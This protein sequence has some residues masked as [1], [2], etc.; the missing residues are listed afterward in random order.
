MDVQ[1]GWALRPL[2]VNEVNEMVEMINDF[3][4]ML[5]HST[6]TGICLAF[7]I[8]ALMGIWKW[9]LGVM[10]RALFYLFPGLKTWADKRRKKDNGNDN[11]GI[12][13]VIAD[14]IFLIVSSIKKMLA[15]HKEKPEE[16][17]GDEKTE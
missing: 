4:D 2:P 7:W 13:H 14:L 17:P 11:I 15:K 12:S 1:R 8:I 3:M 16:Q 5:V 9:F 10:K 6:I